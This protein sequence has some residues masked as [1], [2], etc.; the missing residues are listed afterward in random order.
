MLRQ[1]RRRRH[2]PL[3][4]RRRRR[5]APTDRSIKSCPP[6]CASSGEWNSRS[7]VRP[8]QVPQNKCAGN[9]YTYNVIYCSSA[10]GRVCHRH[11]SVRPRAPGSLLLQRSAG[12]SI[13]VPPL[14]RGD[15]HALPDHLQR[16]IMIR[17]Q[18]TTSANVCESQSF[19]I[20]VA[21]EEPD[22]LQPRQ[23]LGHS[24]GLLRGE[25]VLLQWAAYIQQ[26]GQQQRQS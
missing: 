11:Q 16:I 24:L 20:I 6:L 4:R 2:E 15:Q 23:H 8:P 22:H 9:T 14:K 1:R 12:R 10:R 19:E 17:T 3:S 26:P 7:R 21:Y 25:V 18:D 13:V 5:K